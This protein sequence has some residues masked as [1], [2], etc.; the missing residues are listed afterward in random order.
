VSNDKRTP[1]QMKGQNGSCETMLV[2]LND[3]PEAG[4]VNINAHD[5]DPDVHTKAKAAKAAAKTD[6]SEGGPTATDFTQ[7][8]KKELNAWLDE[9]EVA[10]NPG[11]KNDDLIALCVQTEQ[12]S[13]Q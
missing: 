3:N 2:T 11:A 1:E 6:E 5:F 7:F 4:V 12:A 8:T 10:H 13:Q 9:R